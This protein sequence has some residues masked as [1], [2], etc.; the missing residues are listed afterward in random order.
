MMVYY[1]LA[2]TFRWGERR[3][4]STVP[5]LYLFYTL[6]VAHGWHNLSNGLNLGG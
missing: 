2:I 4:V 1:E 3:L 6:P 5:E